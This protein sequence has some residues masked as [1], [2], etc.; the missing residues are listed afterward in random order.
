[1]WGDLNTPGRCAQGPCAAHSTQMRRGEVCGVISS[2]PRPSFRRSESSLDNDSFDMT[3]SQALIS[4]LQWDGSSDLS[5]SDSASSKTSENQGWG[6]GTSSSE[7]R[8]TK[9]KK[10]HMSLILPS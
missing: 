7:S 10:S 9:K 4:R 8:K 6:L 1:M 5:P 3:D 2:D